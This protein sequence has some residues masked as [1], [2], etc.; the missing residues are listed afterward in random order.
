MARG[1]KHTVNGELLTK[2]E[3]VKAYGWSESAISKRMRKG[4]SLEEAVNVDKNPPPKTEKVCSRCHI[5]KPMAEY[6]FSYKKSG[7]RESYCKPCRRIIRRESGE[8]HKEREATRAR[9]Y[10]LRKKYGIDSQKYEEM[11]TQQGGVC[12]GCKNKCITGNRLAVDHCHDTGKVR[13]LLC[14]L[15]NRALGSSKDNPTTLR[16]L[17]DYL[18]RAEAPISAQEKNHTPKNTHTNNQ[19]PQPKSL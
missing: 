11:L 8:K 1:E 17:A 14:G 6:H 15:C 19:H 2:T 5:E 13:G 12:L 18:E 9:N 10:K 3:A 16:R 7:W 4:M